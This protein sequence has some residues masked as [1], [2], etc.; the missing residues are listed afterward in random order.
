[1]SASVC[2]G[3]TACSTRS[4]P[5]AFS[6]CESLKVVVGR[7]SVG[8]GSKCMPRISCGSDRRFFVFSCATIVAPAWRRLALLSA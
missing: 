4:S 3:V 5:L 8:S 6:S 2:A 1:M 7:A